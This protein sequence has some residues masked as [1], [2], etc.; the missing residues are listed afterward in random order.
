MEGVMFKL[1]IPK[2]MFRMAGFGSQTSL[3]VYRK[4]WPAPAV[5]LPNQV[6]INAIMAGICG[7]DLHQVNVNVSIFGSI[8][9]SSEKG[10]LMPMGH[11]VLGVVDAVG[12]DVQSLKAGDRVVYNPVVHCDLFGFEPCSACRANNWESCL[13]HVGIGDGSE[14]EAR[15]GGRDHFQHQVHGGYCSQMV[16]FGPQ[17]MKVP[18]A[19]PDAV[20]V[21]A[22]PFSVAI[23][24]VFRNPP[25]ENET[26][27]VVGCGIIGLLVIAAVRATG[28]PCKVI[29]VAR[30][31]FQA[32][33]AKNLGADGAISDRDRGEYYASIE[34]ET[35]ATFVKPIFGQRAAYGGAGPNLIFDCIASEASLNDDL[36]IVACN[37][38]IVLVGI[39]VGVTKKIDWAIPIYKEVSVIGT[40]MNGLDTWQGET[41]DDFALALRFLGY[42]PAKF[43][44]L[45]THTFPISQYKEALEHAAHKGKYS[46]IKVAFQYPRDELPA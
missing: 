22:E 25:K 8:F 3:L 24:A 40:I 30:Y 23:H 36:H 6:R 42:T 38:R 35:G 1:N 17:F 15:L 33:A 18:D 29:A 44:G 4:D 14:T 28:I 7:S 34:K 13:T 10:K 31:G 5:E 2:A 32:D 9:V 19:I 16:R 27:V 41:W 37:G 43:E 20:A 21:L 11:E 39:E 12:N 46:A 26:V 45:V